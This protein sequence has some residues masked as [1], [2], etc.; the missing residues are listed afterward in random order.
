MK[1]AG[2]GPLALDHN[3]CIHTIWSVVTPGPFASNLLYD[4]PFHI[5]NLIIADDLQMDNLSLVDHAG[6]PM[7]RFHSL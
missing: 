4:T 3:K 2:Q 1:D 5:L 7:E 6:S